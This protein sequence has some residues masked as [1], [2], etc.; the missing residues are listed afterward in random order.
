MTGLDVSNNVALANYSTNQLTTLDISKNVAIIS[1][2][3]NQLT[4]AMFL[5]MW[6]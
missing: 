5:K 6:L 2:F 3:S 4:T 1:L